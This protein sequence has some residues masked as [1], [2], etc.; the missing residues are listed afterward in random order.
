[1]IF[2]AIGNFA[3]LAWNIVLASNPDFVIGLLR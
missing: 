3:I 2:H 1:V